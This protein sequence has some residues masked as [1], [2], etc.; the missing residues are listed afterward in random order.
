MCAGIR[1]A[2]SYFEQKIWSPVDIFI[3]MLYNFVGCHGDGV[4]EPAM[5][6]AVKNGHS[7]FN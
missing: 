4:L 2:L 3:R 1:T 7:L 6:I 5:L